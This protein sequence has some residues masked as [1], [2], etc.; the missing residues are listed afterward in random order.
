MGSVGIAIMT[1]EPYWYEC[2]KCDFIS[3]QH[4]FLSALMIEV[5][6]HRAV[7]HVP[8]RRGNPAPMRPSQVGKGLSN[9]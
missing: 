8:V 5:N 4:E 3:G 9:A 1:Y 2:D 7:S 6:E